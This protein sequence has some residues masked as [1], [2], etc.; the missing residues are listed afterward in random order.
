M[1]DKALVAAIRPK[2]NGSSTMGMKKSVVATIACSSFNRYTAA[3][4]AVSVPTSKSV[5]CLPCCA[6]CSRVDRTAGEILQP[7]PPPCESEVNRVLG[8]D[9]GCVLIEP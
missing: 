6:P 7:Q 1:S 8:G 5:Y 9:D 3:S 2:S 4:S